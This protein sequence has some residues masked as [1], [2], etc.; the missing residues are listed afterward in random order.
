MLQTLCPRRAEARRKPG[1]ADPYADIPRPSNSPFSK[2]FSLSEAFCGNLAGFEERPPTRNSTP[3]TLRQ[4]QV[5]RMYGPPRKPSK[6]DDRMAR[7][8]AVHF[9]VNPVYRP[10]NWTSA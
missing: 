1:R 10:R 5:E 2:V 9:S 6:L 7:L 4:I 3:W 8:P